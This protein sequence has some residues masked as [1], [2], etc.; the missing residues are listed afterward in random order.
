MKNIIFTIKTSYSEGDY[1]LTVDEG[2]SIEAQI[3][4]AMAA[5][6]FCD[7][8]EIASYKEVDDAYAI[9]RK[10]LFD[11][12][13]SVY[14]TTV[15][16]DYCSGTYTTREAVIRDMHYSMMK[17]W[18]QTYQALDNMQELGVFQNSDELMQCIGEIMGEINNLIDNLKAL[19]V[20]MQEE[21]LCEA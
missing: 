19:G 13:S 4:D 7:D 8:Y 16:D 2:A 11:C 20:K 12:Y 14:G 1:F 17:H 9:S 18:E 10:E 3:Y 21:G 6:S 15:E 5:I